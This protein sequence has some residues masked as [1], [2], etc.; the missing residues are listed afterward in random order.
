MSDR[1]R[2]FLGHPLGLSPLFFTE[3]WERFSYYGIRALLILY[4]TA[5]LEKGGLGLDVP[6]AGAIYGLFTGCAYL[7]ALPAGWIADRFLGQQRSVRLGGALIALGNFGMLMPNLGLFVGALLLIAVGT[8]FLKTSCTTT[9][10]MLYQPGDTRRDSGFSIYYFGINLGAGIAPIIMGYVGQMIQYRYAFV[11][12]GFVML[13]GLGQFT[14]TRSFLEG[15]GLH[16]VTPAT[17][18]DRQ[19][20]N[21]GIGALV[22][23]AAAAVFLQAPVTAISNAFGLILA[24]AAIA[25]FAGLLLSKDFTREERRRIQVVGVLFLAS[26]LFWSIFEQAGSTLNL[27]ADRNTDNRVFGL[28]FPSSWF[29]SVNSIWLYAL[30]PVFVWLWT[31]LGA[32]N[33]STTTKFAFGLFGAGAGFILMMGAAAATQGGTVKVSPLWL[34]GCYLVHTVGEL[35]LSPVGLSAM[36]KLAPARIGGFIMGVFFLS[37][38]VGNYMGGRISSLYESF[39]LTQIFGV[40]GATGLAL[41]LC[42]LLASKAITRLE[43]GAR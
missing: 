9:V 37:I 5:S 19:Y 17:P 26:A 25:T 13:A 20:L 32:R 24:L 16:P 12:A 11:V 43:G 14:F 31:A 10:G 22:L 29:Q 2:A 18:Q 40:V 30:T 1:D 6:T 42:L 4:M 27:F 15:R 41:G 33:P 28:P 38:S 39:P 23:L 8:G 7:T 21:L 34:I 3:M 35:C 36:T